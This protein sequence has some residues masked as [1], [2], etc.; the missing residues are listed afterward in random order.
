M[1]EAHLDSMHLGVPDRFSMK[2]KYF[3]YYVIN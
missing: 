1:I 3:T 2:Q